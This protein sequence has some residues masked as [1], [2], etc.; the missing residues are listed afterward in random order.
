[1]TDSEPTFADRVARLV[2][3]IPHGKVATYGQIAGMAG[4]PRGARM[5]VRV[6]RTKS[7]QLGLPWHRVVNVKGHIALTGEGARVQR[8]ALTSEKV[9]VNPDGG[10]SLARFQWRP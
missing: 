5:V 7:E 4:S 6:L 1:V 3:R 8:A 2:K 10:I 9:K